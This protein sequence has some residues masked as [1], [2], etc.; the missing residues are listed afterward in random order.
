[1]TVARQRTVGGVGHRLHGQWGVRR[2]R[3]VLRPGAPAPG[4]VLAGERRRQLL[5]EAE[6]VGDVGLH[7]GAHRRDAQT[8]VPHDHRRHAVGRQRVEGGIP[9]HL[10]V[11]VGV[12]V[13]QPGGDEGSGG[14]DDL[15]AV[16]VEVGAHLDDATVADPDIAAMRRCAGAVHDRAAADE[17]VAHVCH[18][19]VVSRETVV[20]AGTASTAERGQAR[21]ACR[22]EG[23]SRGVRP[24]PC[25][26]GPASGCPTA[27]WSQRRET[28]HDEVP[29][30]PGSGTLSV[31]PMAISRP[32]AVLPGRD[33]R[34]RRDPCLPASRRSA[35]PGGG[36]RPAPG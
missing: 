32:R 3:V 26:V 12:A 20:K 15:F 16:G 14:I 10:E 23:N 7:I 30:P 2:G 34:V 22:L 31:S 29:D 33:R 27:N 5:D 25:G 36:R 18:P 28:W 6:E 17:E 9:E 24:T 11:V 19:V 1:M 4:H 35:W 21:P 13:D 8:T